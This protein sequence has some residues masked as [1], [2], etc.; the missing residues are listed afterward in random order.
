MPSSSSVLSC[1]SKQRHEHRLQMV[2]QRA[3][4]LSAIWKEDILWLRLDVVDLPYLQSLRRSQSCRSCHQK[5][6]KKRRKSPWEPVGRCESSSDSSWWMEAGLPV[7]I[8]EH[9][10]IFNTSSS[11]VLHTVRKCL[12]IKSTTLKW[13]FIK[14]HSTWGDIWSCVGTY[15]LISIYIII[16]AVVIQL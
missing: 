4:T 13:R 11:G 3:Y 10:Y 15:F 5:K 9:K 8:K 1:S 12:C 6:K 7:S 16:R 14:L 2:L